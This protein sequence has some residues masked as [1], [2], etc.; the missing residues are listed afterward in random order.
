MEAEAQTV[1]LVLTA[2]A[3]PASGIVVA[4]IAMGAFGYFPDKNIFYLSKKEV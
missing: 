3:G 4:L 2:V 1:E